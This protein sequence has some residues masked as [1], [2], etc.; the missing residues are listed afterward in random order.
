MSDVMRD[1][2]FHL[3]H[4]FQCF[5]KQNNLFYWCMLSRKKKKKLNVMQDKGHNTAN[6]PTFE[7]TSPGNH[8]YTSHRKEK[9]LA[10][11]H[12]IFNKKYSGLSHIH[13]WFSLKVILLRYVISGGCPLLRRN[14]W[15]RVIYIMFSCKVL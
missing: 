6:L 4:I 7:I 1:K 11:Q 9:K 14:F 5:E 10:L 13:H 3:K 12:L 15:H 2:V 8:A